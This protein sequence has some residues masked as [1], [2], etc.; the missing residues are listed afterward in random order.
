M[1]HPQKPSLKASFAANYS[2][3]IARAVEWLGDRYLLAKPINAAPTG[4]RRPG[5]LGGGGIL[6]EFVGLAARKVD[7]DDHGAI[8]RG[9]AHRR[10]QVSH[11][12]PPNVATKLVTNGSRSPGAT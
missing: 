2:P 9:R 3:A 12:V 7:P 1:T 10:I 5:D 8:C 4:F 11:A 6:D